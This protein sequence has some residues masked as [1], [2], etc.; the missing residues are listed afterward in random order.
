MNC[1]SNSLPNPTL[2]LENDYVIVNIFNK[3]H[4]MDI[5]DAISEAIMILQ[6]IDNE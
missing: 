1:K 2:R 5:N 3:T 4:N 6:G